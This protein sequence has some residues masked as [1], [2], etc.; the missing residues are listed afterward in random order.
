[1]AEYD[2]I[3]IGGGPAGMM[4]A[5]K[6][7]EAGLKPIIVEKNKLLGRK[8]RITGKGRC[9]ITNDCGREAFFAEICSGSKFLY[10]AYSR[11]SNIDLI[12]F[13]NDNGL[14]TV[15][16]RGGRVFPE[17]QKAYDVAELFVKLLKEHKVPVLYDSKVTEILTED[18][19]VKGVKTIT[20]GKMQELFSRNVLLASGGMT[21][22]LTGSNGDGYLLAKK[23]GHTVTDLKPSLVALKC[24]QKDICASL[25]GLSLKNVSISL[26]GGSKTLYSDFGEMVFTDSGVSGP[27]VLSAS[28]HV[29]EKA[30]ADTFRLTIDL[31]PA[32]DET[33]LDARLV[34]DFAVNSKK[35]YKNY[36]SELLPSKLIPVFVKLSGINPDTPVY[37]INKDA[38]ERIVYLLKH[39]T[40]DITGTEGKDQA[41][42]TAGGI[43]LS[44]VNPRTFESRICK[45]LYFAGEV[46]DIDAYTGG[47]NLTVAFSTGYNAG[48]EIAGKM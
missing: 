1:M 5:L 21:Y 42:V 14:P 37:G 31:K 12:D 4:A 36:L 10:S 41:I 45:G 24:R 34:R 44:E 15:T 30:D 22:P 23:L 2:C 33:K 20:A 18:N 48:I 38:R 7:A 46:L 32:L 3:V 9:N 39:F 40:L 8:L 28:R 47:F 25:E 43:T 6:I 26:T 13:F 11:F 19:S 29:P 35:Q 27:V 17:S 16:E